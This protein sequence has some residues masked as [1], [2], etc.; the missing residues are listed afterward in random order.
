MR[1]QRQEKYPV[2]RVNISAKMIKFFIRGYLTGCVILELNS[3][4]MVKKLEEYIR[5]VFDANMSGM[6]KALWVLAQNR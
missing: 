1:H 6:N 3:F 2:V 4:F 5:M